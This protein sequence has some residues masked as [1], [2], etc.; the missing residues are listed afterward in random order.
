[1]P[2]VGQSLIEICTKGVIE[3][4]S[5]VKPTTT[6]NQENIKSKSIMHLHPHNNIKYS[7]YGLAIH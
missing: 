7:E 4:F 1:M 3:K 2:L 6:I 5:K